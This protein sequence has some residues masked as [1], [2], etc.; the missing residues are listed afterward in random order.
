MA[1]EEADRKTL[2]MRV[3]ALEDKLANVHI[4][5]AEMRAFHKVSALLAAGQAPGVADVP[6][7]QPAA[8]GAMPSAA[9]SPIICVIP[10]ARS[11]VSRQ[12]CYE[13]YCGPC[14]CAPGGGFFG[15]GGFGTLGS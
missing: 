10:R 6:V 11:I 9:L 12:F 13:C 1:E 2:E 5:E 4:S 15:G 7:T 3:A 8:G 14:N